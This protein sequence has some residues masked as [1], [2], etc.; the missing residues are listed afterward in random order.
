MGMRKNIAEICKMI[1]MINTRLATMQRIYETKEFLSHHKKSQQAETGWMPVYHRG[2]TENGSY[3]SDMYL[4]DTD[5]E[6][7]VTVSDGFVIIASYLKNMGVWLSVGHEIT[8]VVAWRP[9]PKPYQ[10][11]HI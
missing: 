3:H 7:L 8:N 6:V 5:E 10:R 9:L 2:W 11:S 1:Y 4:P